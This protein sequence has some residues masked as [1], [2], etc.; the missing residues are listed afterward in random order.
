MEKVA[1]ICKNLPKQNATQ[2]DAPETD[3]AKSKSKIPKPKV[4]GVKKTKSKK[5]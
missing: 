1:E 5:A 2:V 3:G 4:K